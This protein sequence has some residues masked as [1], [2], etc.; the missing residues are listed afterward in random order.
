MVDSGDVNAIQMLTPYA[1]FSGLSMIPLCMSKTYRV[2]LVVGHFHARTERLTLYLVNTNTS[3]L[4]FMVAI[5]NVGGA[6]E[7]TDR[8]LL[9]SRTEWLK[10][11]RRGNKITLS[12]A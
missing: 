4:R 11:I 7:H 12:S 1:N 9:P 5:P 10:Q 3:P 6:L 8:R 2:L